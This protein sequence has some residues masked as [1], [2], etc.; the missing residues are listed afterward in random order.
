MTS[1]TTFALLSS[2]YA[3]IEDKT[4][5]LVE[6]AARVGLK[7]SSKKS[8]VMRINARKVNDEQVDDV[9]EFLY[10]GALLDKEGGANKDI[11]QI[12]SKARQTFY[13]LQRIWN[14]SEISRK[15]KIQLFKTIV[16]AVLMYGCKTWKVKKTEAKKLNAFQ[17]KC[18]KRILRIRWPRTFSNSLIIHQV[19]TKEIMTVT[20]VWIPD[21]N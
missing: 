3:D 9:E 1:Q 12:L 15:T 2:R 8:K 20:V 21:L 6:E 18:M 14:S 7:I 10:L 11:Q 5:R 19:K 17:Y 4:S 16:R 13:R